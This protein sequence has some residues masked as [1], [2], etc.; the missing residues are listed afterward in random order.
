MTCA[1]TWIL[2][3]NF[4][5]EYPDD[6]IFISTKSPSESPD[7]LDTVNIPCAK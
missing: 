4:D 5:D 6:V 7:V 3:V 2:G 1:S